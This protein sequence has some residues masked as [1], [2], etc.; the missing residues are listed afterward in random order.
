M[1]RWIRLGLPWWLSGKESACSAGATGDVGSIPGLGRSPW[2]RAW[3]PTLVFL[4]EKPMGRGA[5]QATVHR[6]PKNQ[7]RLKPLSTHTSTNQLKVTIKGRLISESKLPKCIILSEQVWD[8]ETQTYPLCPSE[9]GKRLW[10]SGIIYTATHMQTLTYMWASGLFTVRQCP[11]GQS[12]RYNLGS[13][14][15]PVILA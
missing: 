5:W 8:W 2:R 4:P 3:Q 11:S 12:P 15:I 13:L 1:Y 7:T 6:V 14:L 9:G 10:I